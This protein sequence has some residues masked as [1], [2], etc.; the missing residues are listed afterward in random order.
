MG[1]KNMTQLVTKIRAS[2]YLPKQRMEAPKPPVKMSRRHNL[3]S[4]DT[5]KGASRAFVARDG[6]PISIEPIKAPRSKT[7]A[8]IG[9]NIQRRRYA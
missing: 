6:K 5:K 9:R 1:S 8:Q 4:V 3:S 2:G 7:L